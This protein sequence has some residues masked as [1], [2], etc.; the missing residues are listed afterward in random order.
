MDFEYT[1]FEQ[2]EV[3]RKYEINK[4]KKGGENRCQFKKTNNI[5]QL[6]KQ[7]K[8]ISCFMSLKSL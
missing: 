1:N 2:R 6:E 4:I 5:I 7:I 3:S 8:L